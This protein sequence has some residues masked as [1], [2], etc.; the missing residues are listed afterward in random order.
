MVIGLDWILGMSSQVPFVMVLCGIC[1]SSILYNTRAFI[2][3]CPR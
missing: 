3:V 1:R 2:V